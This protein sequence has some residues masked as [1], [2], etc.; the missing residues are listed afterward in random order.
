MKF[1]NLFTKKSSDCSDCKE[2]KSLVNNLTKSVQSLTK[3]VKTLQQRQVRLELLVAGSAGGQ[4]RTC[5]E[6]A[7]DESSSGEK[8]GRTE[9]ST[10]NEERAGTGADDASEDDWEN[11]P[12]SIDDDSEVFSLE[13]DSVDS[14]EIVEEDRNR[15]LTNGFWNVGN[16]CFQNSTFHLAYDVPDIRNTIFSGDASLDIVLQESQKILRRIRDGGS[17]M[18]TSRFN[19]AL[20]FAKLGTQNGISKST[21]I[22]L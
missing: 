11:E 19:D 1:P 10:F 17:P 8:R 20:R 4:K 9:S 16:T 18:D 14:C 21:K 22:G 2:L 6:I 15:T 3:K 13:S 7:T 5:G 12:I